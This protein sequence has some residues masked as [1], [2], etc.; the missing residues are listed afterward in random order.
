MPRYA[1]QYWQ[2]CTVS[3]M[4]SSGH[5]EKCAYSSATSHG[6]QQAVVDLDDLLH[7]LRGYPVACRGPGV[8]CHDYASL[9]AKRQRGGSMCDLD[10][11]VWVR[12][13]VGHCAEP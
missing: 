3:L 2:S 6:A 12:V 10:G 9:E 11:A 1:S 4:V 13:V 7:R 5:G 8:C